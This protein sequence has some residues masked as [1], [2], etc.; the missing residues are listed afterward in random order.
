MFK[1]TFICFFLLWIN[2]KVYPQNIEFRKENFPGRETSFYEAVK[3]LN[4]GKKL[5]LKEEVNYLQ[6]KENFEVAYRFHPSNALLCFNLGLC[7]LELGEK[8]KAMKFLLNA[9]EL[10]PQLKGDLFYYLGKGYQLH[11][12]WDSALVSY[13]K[14]QLSLSKSETEKIS[15]VEKRKLECYNGIEL[16]KNKNNVKIQNLGN[17][18]NT[19]FEEYTPYITADEEKLYFTS[20]RKLTGD[21]KYLRTWDESNEDIFVAT[22][23]NQVWGPAINAGSKVNTSSHDAVCGIFPD[24]Q[25][26]IVFKGDVNSGD[27]FYVKYENGIWGDLISFGP[28][29]NTEDHESSACLTSDGKK[30]Y[31]VSDKP[32]GIGGRDIYVSNFSVS[33]NS[34]DV[35]INLGPE[36]NTIYDEEGVFLH[37]DNKTLFFASNGSL[38]IGG[39]DILKSELH[40]DHWTKP[41]NLGIPINT[42]DEDVFVSVSGN[43]KNIYF[44][45]NRAEGYGSKDL[46]LA[47]SE[48]GVLSPNMFLLTGEITSE[49]SGKPV[50]ATIDLIDL[51][52]NQK[53][54]RFN[55]DQESGK[56]VI[57]LPGGKSY[58]TVTY[59]DGYIFESENI[60]VSDTANFK[61][62]KRNQKLK[63]IENNTS[64]NLRNIFFETGKVT[65]LKTSENELD[66]VANFLF[67]NP[68]VKIEIYGHTD[69]SGDPSSNLILSQQRCEEVFKELL[70]REVPASRLSYKGLGETSP[71]SSN[72]T[73][74]GR[75]KNRRI[76]F[77]IVIL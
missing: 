41:V 1:T 47:M 15:L 75:K 14:H 73:A 2:I 76:E 56:Y 10:D 27:L 24:G 71:L 69:N 19:I 39:Y 11:S 57:P 65:L 54:G 13:N 72:A 6:A 48:E 42:P 53:I 49:A 55:N 32:E 31:F 28:T 66:N 46:Y 20:R 52:T 51:T 60:D 45:S 36:I 44:S 64:G 12:Q 29:I 33:T 21:S 37:P 35:A 26:L 16:S 74:E 25:T 38:S 61:E 3:A 43:G 62:V 17:T 67:L 63:K 9:K 8:E 58:G 50:N 70:K 68:T 34:W 30:L 77:R 5:L 40:N 23:T 59:A 18:I 4:K 22:K 7:L